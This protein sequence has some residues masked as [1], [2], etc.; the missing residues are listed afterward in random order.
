MRK[1]FLSVAL[2]ATI[3]LTAFTAANTSNWK[4]KEDYAIKFSGTDVEGTFESF[5]GTIQF[6]EKIPENSK[7]EITIETGSIATGNGMKNRHAKS[8][9]WF[10]AKQ[11]P[12]IKFTSK[13]VAK[14]NGQFTTEGTLAMHG[15]E[16]TVVIPF[17]FKDKV[18][19]GTFSLDRLDFGIGDMEGMSKKVSNQIDLDI[20]VPVTE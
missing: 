12:A 1:E 14:V 2:V 10:D 18:F 8:D 3:A 17:N 16:K 4:I 15:V 20:T 5:K 11:F 13:K 9:K 7:F 19:R 6:D